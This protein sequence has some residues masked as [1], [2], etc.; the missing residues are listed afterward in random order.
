MRTSEA[1]GTVK[2]RY[3]NKNQQL[4][5][6]PIAVCSSWSVHDPRDMMAVCEVERHPLQSTEISL[7]GPPVGL[8]SLHWALDEAGDNE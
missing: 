4:R 2:T 1:T 6:L 5:C 7:A 3:E 8:F